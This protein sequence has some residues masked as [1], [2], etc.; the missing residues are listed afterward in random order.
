MNIGRN[1][2]KR[3]LTAKIE[4]FFDG[5]CGCPSVERID[6]EKNCFCKF[7]KKHIVV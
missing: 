4:I 1:I 5:E 3:R 7:K 6:T 2:I